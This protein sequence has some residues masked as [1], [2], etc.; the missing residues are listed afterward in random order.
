[1]HLMGGLGFFLGGF[2]RVGQYYNY[3]TAHEIAN[4]LLLSVICLTIPAACAAW[5][6]GNNPGLSPASIQR[7]ILDLSRGTSVILLFVYAAFLLFS[8]K[9]HASVFNLPSRQS[10]KRASMKLFATDKKLQGDRL[11]IIRRRGTE[12]LAEPSSEQNEEENKKDGGEAKQAWLSK[13]QAL[14]VMLI[15]TVILAFNLKFATDSL[16]GLMQN[17]G[18]GQTFIGMILLPLLGN[19]ITPLAAALN[20]NMDLC[21]STTLGKCLQNSI[22]VVPMMVILGWIMDIDAMSL[23]FDGFEVALLFILM[24]SIIS[25]IKGGQ[26]NW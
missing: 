2:N 10:Q 20:D 18:L 12:S 7:G 16:E 23:E 11:I 3:D 24:I 13:W 4:L 17:A 21:I 5:A 22:V 6:G 25:I 19:D 1:M 8:L 14:I 9:T 26:S 15:T